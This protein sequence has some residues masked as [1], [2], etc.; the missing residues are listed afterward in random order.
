MPTLL[1]TLAS[2]I[3]ALIAQRH[4]ANATPLSAPAR[5]PLRAAGLL[6]D[7]SGFTALTERLAGHGPSGVEELTSVLN[8]SF[9]QILDLIEAHGGDVVKFAGDALLALWPAADGDLAVVALRA[10]ECAQAIHTRMENFYRLIDSERMALRIGVAAGDMV[11]IQVG[12]VYGRW[13]FLVAG[14]PLIQMGAAERLACPGEVVLAPNAWALVS[15]HCAGTPLSAKSQEIRDRSLEIASQAPS[16]KLQAPRLYMRLDTIHAP[17]PP[18]PAQRPALVPGMDTALRS[19]IPGAVLS[20]LVAGETSWLA[21]LRRVTVL[22]INL[23]LIGASTPLDQAQTVVRALQTMLYRY[24]GSLNKIS[25]DDKGATLVAALGLPPLAHED[26]AARAVQ[27]ALSIAQTLR[28]MGL[29]CAIGVASGQAFCGEIG[30]RDRREYTMIGDVVNLAARLMQA[31]DHRPPTTDHRPPTTGDHQAFSAQNSTL[32]TQ[33][34][35]LA[36]QSAILCDEATF[37]LAR[38]R[39]A[40]VPLPPIVVKGKAEPVRA[41]CPSGE[42]ASGPQARSPKSN[43]EL[44][45]RAIEQAALAAQLHA[46]LRGDPGGVVVIEGEAGMGKSTLIERLRQLAAGLQIATLIGA[47]DTTEQSTPYHAW[48]PILAQ[49][50]DLG[51]AGIHEARIMELLGASEAA[52]APLLNAVL[53][54]ELPESQLTAQLAGQRR[55]EA[56]RDLLLRLLQRAAARAATADPGGCALV[57]LGLLGSGT[58]REPARA[59]VVAGG[60][61]APAQ[62]RSIGR[63]GTA[64][65]PPTAGDGKSPA[66][67][68]CARAGGGDRTGLPAAGRRGV[69]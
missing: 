6:A 12:G 18:R 30:S 58:G 42:A 37:Q 27:A 50:F 60:H 63:R 49:I 38:S 31:A 29:R 9:G 10:A 69:A 22:F 55:A 39:I 24:E 43:G 36:S 19:F 56:T 61:A 11:A 40:F 41:Y 32:N 34:S 35:T 26:D 65:V 52:L 54:L 3:P 16:S 5:Y 33:H 45:G 23:P 66:A 53:P 68:G 64:G 59:P 7:I 20:R 8:V 15:D 51:T 44:V 2:Y 13:E 4:T 25:V 17:L 28:E 47:G 21:E 1:D 48:R 62:R 67:S 57:R 46:L 14:E